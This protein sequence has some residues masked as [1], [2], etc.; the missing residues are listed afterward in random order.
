MRPCGRASGIV[1]GCSVD[2]VV[3]RAA[4]GV[5]FWPQA[6]QNM[7]FTG[8]SK[9]QFGHGRVPPAADGAGEG[10]EGGA[11]IGG[12]GAPIGG[13]PGG[14]PKPGGGPYGDGAGAGEAPIA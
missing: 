8:T 11:P 13:P 5:S 12:G 1:A 10:A 6:P 2:P 9:P 4:T 7:K 14:G 3:G